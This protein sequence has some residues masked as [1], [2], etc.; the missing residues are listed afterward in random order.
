MNFIDIIR[1]FLAVII[2]V[3][4]VLAVL[5]VLWIIIKFFKKIL[6]KKPDAEP[7]IA[8]SENVII[9][10]IEPENKKST[11]RVNK[12]AEIKKED[13]DDG[14]LIAVLMAAILEFESAETGITPSALRIK[15]F[16][17]VGNEMA[18]RN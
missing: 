7:V 10:P 6:Y 17:R 13:D 15:S 3:G 2:S 4:I 1:E 16:K 11:Q 9:S 8:P 14:E 12:P 5:I 18:W